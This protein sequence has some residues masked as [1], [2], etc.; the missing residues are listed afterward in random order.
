VSAAVA[1]V[2][3]DPVNLAEATLGMVPLGLL[4]AALGYLAAG[5]LTTAVDTGL[6]SL[7][8]AAWFFLSF[9]GPDLKLPDATLR[10]SP[11]Y[12]YGTPLMHGLQFANLV[13]V[14][15]AGAVALVLA[16]LRF[17]RRDIGV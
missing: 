11:F 6:I 13:V 4:I 1:G 15:A 2:T 8:L 14:L 3:L 16:T 7:L 10:L 17:S 9:I 5:W 12:Y